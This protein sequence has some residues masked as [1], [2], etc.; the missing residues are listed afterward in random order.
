VS[1]HALHGSLA[2]QFYNSTGS[3]TAT[4]GVVA[5]Q[6]KKSV[7]TQGWSSR[8]GPRSRSGAVQGDS[9]GDTAERLW[10]GVEGL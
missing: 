5:G 6:K 8:G 7:T 10:A 9:A 1:Q 3:H 4:R 2:D